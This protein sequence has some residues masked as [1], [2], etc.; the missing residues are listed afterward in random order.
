LLWAT[1]ANAACATLSLPPRCR[2]KC[3]KC[4]GGC[5]VVVVVVGV[6]NPVVDELALFTW[7]LLLLLLSLPLP[8]AL[9]T[10]I[11]SGAAP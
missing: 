10:T 6:V 9:P 3:V 5:G 1:H 8:V 11:V 4:E 7:L 2:N